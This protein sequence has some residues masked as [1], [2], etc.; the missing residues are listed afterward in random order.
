MFAPVIGSPG[1]LMSSTSIPLS[2][3]WIETP[4]GS[5]TEFAEMEIVVKITN[6]MK[7]G[8]SIFIVISSPEIGKYCTLNLE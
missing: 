6:I 4:A 8:L 5:E 3:R 1:F 2:R 7:S